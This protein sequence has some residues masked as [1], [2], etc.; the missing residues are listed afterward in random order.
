MLAL[1]FQ[2]KPLWLFETLLHSNEE[3]NRFLAVDDAMVVAQGQ[4]HHGAR[5]NLPVTH[6]SAILNT[7]HTKDTRLRRIEDGRR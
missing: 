2:D 5:Y 1:E 3:G 6:N 4:I 7:V